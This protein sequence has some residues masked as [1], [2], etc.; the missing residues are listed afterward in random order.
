M[1]R[2]IGDLQYKN[3]MNTFDLEQ[4]AKSKRAA[5]APSDARGDFISNQAHIKSIQLNNDR[6]YV[7]M[8]STDGISDVTD[9]KPLMDYAMESFAAGTRAT[10]IAT[11][12]TSRVASRPASD[13]C[14]LVLVFL[15]GTKS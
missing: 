14:T 11:E 1:S 3:P 7:L 5:A 15:D 8:I 6:R 13:N 2:A 9:A 12:I 4:T 10:D